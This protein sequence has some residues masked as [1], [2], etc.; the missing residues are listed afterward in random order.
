MQKRTYEVYGGWAILPKMLSRK[1]VV[2]LGSDMAAYYN[3][4][5]FDQ[6]RL[7]VLLQN[8]VSLNPNAINH[9]AAFQMATKAGARALGLE[10]GELKIEKKQT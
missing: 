9:K 6:M 10:S 5:M 1:V 4:S 2:G 3:L 8:V 7:S